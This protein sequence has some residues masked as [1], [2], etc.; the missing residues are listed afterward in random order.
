MAVAITQDKEAW[1]SAYQK[2]RA[3]EY[4][5]FIYLATLNFAGALEAVVEMSALPQEKELKILELGTGTG[6]LS[7][8]I[9]TK[10]PKAA[11]TGIDGSEAMLKAAS[12][13]LRDFQNRLQLLQSSFEKYDWSKHRHYYNLIVS[14]F[15]L[16]HLEH[17]K[18]AALFKDLWGTLTP[19]GLF[20]AADYVRSAYD[21]VQKRYEEL[22]VEARCRKLEQ[23]L[24]QKLNK[25]DVAREHE[26]T[27]RAEGDNPAVL[28]D[29]TRW[30]R[31]AG[32][33]QVECHWKD[34]CYAVFG[35]QKT[36]LV[37]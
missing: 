5:S 22:W 2:K 12:R 13:N 1:R 29:V 11:L 26:E 35:G 7:K 23:A 16:H 9:L 18:M 6:L 17:K 37:T 32:F 28:E 36:W 10:F 34:Y 31:E 27:K 20:I 33:L 19:G 14:S 15:S 30:L 4:D 21:S 25:A 24:G 3:D 8:K